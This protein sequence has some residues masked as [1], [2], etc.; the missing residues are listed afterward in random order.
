[1][2][3][4]QSMQRANMSVAIVCMVNNTALKAQQ[5]HHQLEADFNL[6]QSTPPSH[7]SEHSSSL[8][9]LNETSSL[10]A[11]EHDCKSSSFI[12]RFRTHQVSFY[13]ISSDDNFI[14]FSYR[15]MKLL[16]MNEGWAVC[17]VKAC[18]SE[19]WTL[20]LSSRI[21]SVEE[22]LSI[23]GL[24]LSSVY[25]GNVFTQVSYE[26]FKRLIPESTHL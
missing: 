17:L 11:P 10:L 1:M 25:I 23:Q 12:S 15:T 19:W 5:Q 18:A 21:G 24:I 7:L 20:G 4:I 8:L 26:L 22:C 6:S 14:I 9:H 3:A 2:L 16:P 13:L